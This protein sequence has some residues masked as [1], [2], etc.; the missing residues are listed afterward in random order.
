MHKVYVDVYSLCI[1]DVSCY[2]MFMDCFN[3]TSVRMQNSG[4]SLVSMRNLI[5]T[6]TV[7]VLPMCIQYF[8]CSVLLLTSDG[9]D[10][11]FLAGSQSLH[12]LEATPLLC[13]IPSRSTREVTCGS[14]PQPVTNRIWYIGTLVPSLLLWDNSEACVT[15]FF[16]LEFSIAVKLQLPTELAGFIIYSILSAFH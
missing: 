8:H 5:L 14:S 10:L 11:H 1:P 4:M 16:P 2:L 12:P 6:D 9:Q 3:P 15:Y 13:T 7:D